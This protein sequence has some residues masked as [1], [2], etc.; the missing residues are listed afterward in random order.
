[1]MTIHICP[2]MDFLDT[3]MCIQIIF[4]E[5]IIFLK[6]IYTKSYYHEIDFSSLN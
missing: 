3:N 5:S 6:N 4:Q 1:M 2:A